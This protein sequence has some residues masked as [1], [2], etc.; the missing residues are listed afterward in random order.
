MA[1]LIN[2]PQAAARYLWTI[3]S[4]PMCCGTVVENWDVR[5]IFHVYYGHLIGHLSSEISKLL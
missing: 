3:H 2:D 5:G 4:L 1:L